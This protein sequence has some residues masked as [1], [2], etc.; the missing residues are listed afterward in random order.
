MRYLAGF[1]ALA[2]E[3]FAGILVP[4][5]AGNPVVIVPRLEESKARE[6]SV[7]KDIK[8]YSDSE[9]PATLIEK[10][11]EELELKKATF[12]VEGFLPFK[13]YRMLVGC[14]PDIETW[15]ASALFSELRIVK[16][17]EELGTIEKAAE[18]VAEG[19]QSGID[20]IK[21]GVSELAISCQIER[22]IKERGGESIPFCIVLSGPNSALPHGETS[23][24]KVERKDVVLMDVGALYNGYYG[25]LTRTVFVGEATQKERQIY[26]VV[27]EA[28]RRAIETVRPGIKAEEIDATARNVIEKA[29]FGQYFTHRTGHGLG[30]EV[31][32]EPYICE[33]N[34]MPLQPGMVFTVEPGIYLSG[35]FGVRIEDNVA[36][37][38]TGVK[39]LDHISKELIVIH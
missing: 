2:I 29:G 33:G 14:S 9:N 7:F 34:K 13:F 12:G 27:A 26:Q 6:R 32:E 38:K 21:P 25:D 19:I 30:L 36:V 5:D 3:R 22:V 24:R 17:E 35:K 1:S 16:S 20:S 4:V 11:V 8:T 10:T 18:I 37:S 15:D 31:H 28:N 23:N 39:I